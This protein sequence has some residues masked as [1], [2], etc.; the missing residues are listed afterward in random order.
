MNRYLPQSPTIVKPNIIIKEIKHKIEKPKIDLLVKRD[1]DAVDDDFKPPE[2]RLPRHNYPSQGIKR[3]INIPTRGYPD[4]YQN[5]GLLVRKADERI[6]KLFGRQKF[7]GSSQWEYYTVDSYNMQKVPLKINGS[8]ELS[9]NDVVA[10]PWLDQ[11]KGK[12]EVK[13]FDYDAPRYNP[14]V[15]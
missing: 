13:I 4:N 11:G 15:F 12:F 8:K 2:R 6:L 5:L 14:N 9:N 10:V 3:I 7:P 1:R